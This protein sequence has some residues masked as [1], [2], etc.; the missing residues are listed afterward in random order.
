M[1]RAPVG[2]LAAVLVAFQIVRLAG[3]SYIDP[4]SG[5]FAIQIIIAAV[6]GGL[7]SARLWFRYVFGRIIGWFRRSMPEASPPAE[8]ASR[9][10]G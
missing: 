3:R 9:E 7:L 6:L 4:G 8:E 10:D 5:S 1:A 2:A